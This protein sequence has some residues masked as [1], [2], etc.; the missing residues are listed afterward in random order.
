MKDYIKNRIEYLNDRIDSILKRIKE[1]E[2]NSGDIVNLGLELNI[3]LI[4]LDELRTL[5]IYL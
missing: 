2:V 3:I 4:Q 1:R 5:K